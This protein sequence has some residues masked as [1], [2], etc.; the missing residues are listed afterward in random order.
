[1]LKINNSIL[2]K[3]PVIK[4][5]NIDLSFF[6]FFQLFS[7]TTPQFNSKPKY[8]IVLNNW[9]HSIDKKLPTKTPLLFRKLKTQLFT[10]KTYM[11]R[12]NNNYSNFYYQNTS[13]C[14]NK[15]ALLYTFKINWLN[16]LHL[17]LYLYNINFYNQNY[18]HVFLTLNKKNKG[19]NKIKS[20]NI[21]LLNYKY[22]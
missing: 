13:N 11:T 1:L 10:T 2:T 6:H 18:L 4:Y 20:N 21:F 7:K 15:L 14:V 16:L 22:L 19:N 17:Y 5:F 12:Y 3:K 8:L 9:N